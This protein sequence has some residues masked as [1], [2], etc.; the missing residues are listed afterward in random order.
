[1]SCVFRMEVKQSKELIV[2]LM[3]KIQRGSDTKTK[4]KGKGIDE[5]EERQKRRKVSQLKESCR[6]ALWFS[7]SFNL[8]LLSIYFQVKNTDE[9]ISIDYQSSKQN[10]LSDNQVSTINQL[11]YLLDHFAVSDELYHELSMVFPSL[12]RSHIVRRVR[13]HLSE[14]VAIHRLPDPFFGAYRHLSHSLTEA[15]EA[16]VSRK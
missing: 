8:D 6:S 5:V 11:L 4:N 12:P 15:I 14:N 3:R 7:D 16:L 2:E 1:M 9:C 10:N 13:K